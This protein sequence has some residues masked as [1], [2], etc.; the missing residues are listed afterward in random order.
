MHITGAKPY[1]SLYTG[2][3]FHHSFLGFKKLN[4]WYVKSLLMWCKRWCSKGYFII[5]ITTRLANTSSNFNVNWWY[6]TYIV[7]Q[8]IFQCIL[9]V[10][11]YPDFF[12]I[13]IYLRCAITVQ[14]NVQNKNLSTFHQ[15]KK[16]SDI[17]VP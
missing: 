15:L 2:F 7:A 16:T 17:F 8:K 1:L 9:I 12:D 10:T 6:S 4:L 3:F 13:T 14:L 11:S 5:K